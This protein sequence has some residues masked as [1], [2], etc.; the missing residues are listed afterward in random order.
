MTVH[1]S[2]N[3]VGTVRPDAAGSENSVTLSGLELRFIGLKSRFQAFDV[4]LLFAKNWFLLL[5]T[6]L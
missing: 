5:R 2:G 3:F 4:A 6:M 1:R